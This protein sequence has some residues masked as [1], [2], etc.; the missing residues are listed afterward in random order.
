MTHAPTTPQEDLAFLRAIAQG[1]PGQFAGGSMFLTTGLIYAAQCIGQWAQA[2][3][4]LQLA[5][6]PALVLA[7]GPTVLFLA[8]VVLVLSRTRWGPSG[9]AATRAVNGA[10][11]A[12]GLAN[13][14][15]VAVFAIN[16]WRRQDWLIWEFYP[17]VVFALHG[18]SWLVAYMV[19][20]HAWR[21]W[22]GL[23]A[24]AWAVVLGVLI[25]SLTFI[26]GVAVGLLL[27]M[28][29]PGWIMMRLARPAA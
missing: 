11:A 10:F 8:V 2:T 3:G 19:G 29:L 4:R 15:L 17:A 5:P 26:L 24:L 28:A 25:G 16:A 27:F 12:A 6:T 7:I 9:G 18:A 20:R 1:G 14:A 22:I 23:G 13:F 21:L